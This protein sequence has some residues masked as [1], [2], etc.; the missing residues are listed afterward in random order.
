MELAVDMLGVPSMFLKVEDGALVLEEE[1]LLAAA[2]QVTIFS[3]SRL[4]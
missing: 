1:V 3:P 4:T 2:F